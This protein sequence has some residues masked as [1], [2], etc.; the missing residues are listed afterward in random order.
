MAERLLGSEDDLDLVE[1][2]PFL[3]IVGGH[4]IGD[5]DGVVV[6]DVPENA[7]QLEFERLPESCRIAP[8]TDFHIGRAVGHAVDI[9]C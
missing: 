1:A 2:V 3:D 8:F 7:L 4:L 9:G 6:E 5:L